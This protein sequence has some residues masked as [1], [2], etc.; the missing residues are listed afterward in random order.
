MGPIRV[1]KPSPI[2]TS[3]TELPKERCVGGLASRPE[4]GPVD[5]TVRQSCCAVHASG[6][7]SLINTLKPSMLEGSLRQAAQEAR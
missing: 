2:V 4:T 3:A 5:Y 7:K 1:L 6:L